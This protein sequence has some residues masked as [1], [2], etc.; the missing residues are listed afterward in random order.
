MK[1]RAQRL[2]AVK[3]IIRENLVTSQE[4]LLRFL[5]EHGYNI[6]QATLS[7]DL[8]VLKVAKLSRGSEGYY[9]ALP[10][11]EERKE[12]ERNYVYDFTRGYVS[13]KFSHNIGVIRTLNGHADSVA[14]ALDNLIDDVVLGTIAGD[15][16]VLAVLDQNATADEFM[17][18]LRRYVPELEE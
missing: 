18:S 2:K 17:S 9:Y 8:K 4:E 11:E 10:S 3:K 7:R 13:I 16:T 14:I 1:E 15:D 12:S 5:Q 6:T